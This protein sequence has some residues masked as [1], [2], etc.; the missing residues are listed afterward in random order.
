MK[1]SWTRNSLYILKHATDLSHY[2]RWIVSLFYGH[3]GKDIL[4]VGSGLG[5]LSQYLPKT[6][7]TL[8]DIQ[9]DFFSYL[10]HRF[11]YKTIKLDI[12]KDSPIKLHHSYDTI[13]CSNVFEHIQD[14]GKAMKN[15]FQTL[16]KNGKF[17]LFVPARP[18]IYGNLDK[19]M[20]HYRRYTK[21]DLSQNAKEAGFKIIKI[22]YVNF[23]GYFTWWLRGRFS[24]TSNTDSL[25]AKIFDTL[26]VPILYLEKYIPIPFGQSLILIAQKK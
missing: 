25:T 21:D 14:D 2:N 9:D 24:S 10:K 3:F 16:K 8:S 6:G 13:F 7:I 26:V 12:E 11:D 17:L 22:K 1:K 23:L 19:A 4:E 18:E 5:G 20:G 15:C